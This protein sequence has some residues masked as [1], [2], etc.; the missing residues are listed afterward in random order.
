M[1]AKSSLHSS[2]FKSQTLNRG[3]RCSKPTPRDR[4]PF[5]APQAASDR[6]AGVNEP[7]STHIVRATRATC[8]IHA[9]PPPSL[10]AWPAAAA[11]GDTT[12]DSSTAIAT[13]AAHPPS[14]KY[15]LARPRP[16][17]G[18]ERARVPSSMKNPSISH[19][20]PSSSFLRPLSL[21]SPRSWQCMERGDGCRRRSY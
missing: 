4:K 20:I 15:L 14:P 12:A 11:T 9:P 7:D 8:H 10:L 1:A 21:S 13:S 3:L 16:E 2:E 19:E 6:A 18:S 17:P 5:S